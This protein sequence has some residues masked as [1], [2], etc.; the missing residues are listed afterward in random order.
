MFAAAAPQGLAPAAPDCSVAPSPR[1]AVQKG[2]PRLR[3]HH[4]RHLSAL[5]ALEAS[6]MEQ[7]YGPAMDPSA[8][9]DYDTVELSREA[10]L[11]AAYELEISAGYRK[12]APPGWSR[13]LRC[14]TMKGESMEMLLDAP[15][16]QTSRGSKHS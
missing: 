2:D 10:K 12:D 4:L 5:E 9:V 7:G 15:G 8:E 14:A 11:D 16:R 6:M 1:A 13:T 3:L